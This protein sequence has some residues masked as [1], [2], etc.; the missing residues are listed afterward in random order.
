MGSKTLMS[1]EY[2]CPFATRP[3]HLI[4][5]CSWKMKWLLVRMDNRRT[6]CSSRN[7]TLEWVHGNRN[8]A[9]YYDATMLHG[10]YILLPSFVDTHPELLH[11]SLRVFLLPSPLNHNGRY[12][13]NQ[14]LSLSLERGLFISSISMPPSSPSRSPWP[15]G[16]PSEVS[17][18]CM[19][20]PIF[21]QDRPSERIIV[22]DLSLDEEDLFPDNSWDE[23]FAK[24]LFNDLNRDLLVPPGDGNIIVL[25][26]SN[27]EEEA[28]EEDTADTDAAPPFVV[29]PLRI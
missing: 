29:K 12:E 14:V 4:T 26:N 8:Y 3:S 27:E 19:R 21:E 9:H 17:F 10:L 18:H 24:K 11:F 20:S 1:L 16:S 5:L 15:P 7:D 2:T 22:V 23:E 6:T 25:S 28:R 13:G